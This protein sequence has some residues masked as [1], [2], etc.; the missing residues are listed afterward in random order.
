MRIARVFPRKTNATP[1]DDLCFFD[2]PPLL[3]LP[4]IDEVHVSCAFTYDKI[5]AY[6][7]A[8]AWETAG[9]PVKIGGPA[10]FDRGGDFT[11]GM[12][13]KRGY[14]MTSR[15][16]NNHCWFC[17]VHG[18][19]GQIREIP[20]NEGYNVLD[21]NLLQCSDMHVNSVFDML[22]RQKEK[23]IFTGGL[24]A[25][26]LKPWHCRRLRE[27]RTKRAYFAYDTPDDLEPLIE[28]GKMLLDAG[29][30]RE[31][32]S[33]CCYCLIGYKGDTFEKSG[34]RLHQAIDAGF[35][36]YAMLYRDAQGRIDKAWRQFQRE[37]V[38]PEIV[39][40]ATKKAWTNLQEE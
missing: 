13:I 7:L 3:T 26:I 38:R 20:I 21:S 14:V 8:Y 25:R 19:E 32:H 2:D 40:T 16:C 39:T 30:T 1:T 35:V 6:Q 23:P 37:W 28:A 9:V 24:E 5:K 18:R 10:F 17:S 36:P 34:M 15:G 33:L 27:I 11:P 4:E 22:S 12:Y 29:F 31:S